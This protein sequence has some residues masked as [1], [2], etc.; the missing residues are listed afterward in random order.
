VAAPNIVSYQVRV[1]PNEHEV[2]V[3]LQLEG[4]AAEEEVRLEVPTWVPGDYAFMQ[5]GRDLF[6]LK[7][8]D[9]RTG[10]ELTVTR[11]HWQGFR[12]RGGQGSVLVSY[13][14][15]AYV[16]D[17]GEPCGLVENDYA[18]LLGTRYLR[19]PASPGPCRVTYQLPA[20]WAFH[21][22]SGASQVGEGPAW[23]YPSFEVL[24]DTPVVL[25]R[26]DC[27]ERLIQ[28]TPFYF[29]FLDNALGYESQVELLLDG[30]ARIV[31]ALYEVFGSFP[32]HDYTF[33][34]SLSPVNEWGLEHLSSSMC[35]L[36]PDLFIDP[37][38]R[39]YGM[40]VCA[41]ELFHAW[42]VRRLRPAPLKQFD[43]RNGSFTEG[44][45]VAEGFT[46]YY[47]F[48]ICTR[49][50]VYTPEQFFSAI[51]NYY[52]HLE[53]LPAYE[54]VS[55]VDSSVATYLNHGK[56]PGRCNNSIDY[57][58]K[59]MLIAF[60][61]DAALRLHPRGDSLDDAFRVFYEKFVDSQLGYTTA[62]VLQFFEERQPGLGQLLAREAQQPSGLTVE[63]HLQQLGFRVDR[64]SVFSLGLLFNNAT[65]PAIY[66]VLDSSPAGRC[67]LAPGDVLTR[68]NGF[69]FS[70]AGLMW[71]GGRA[72][73]V[74]LE[75]VRGQRALTMTVT[76]SRRNRISSLRWAGSDEQARRIQAWLRCDDFRPAAG[77]SFNLD[78]Y[79][80][81]HGI[82]TVL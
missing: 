13:R 56:Y 69:P 40:R 30:M 15:Y 53:D 38:K 54:R 16:P 46:R 78:F 20:G 35:G 7:A 11:E 1:L 22:A 9:A 10:K 65:G 63:A 23:D 48:L 41:H 81:F 79:E 57:Y 59:G 82:E 44:L 18:V 67:G 32:F 28:G 61:L 51:V 37:G 36:G 60:D 55:A 12:V 24:L 49:A 43:L 45:W 68:I 71:A 19:V 2:Q 52:R 77:Q 47:E 73:P 17:F 14:A 8:I 29:V 39:A 34:L 6:D 80:N 62:E 26:F 4:P 42:N 70:M 33:I 58:D 74:S 3:E 72:E 64:E 76:P 25:G 27:R 75:V 5:Y 21:H 66:N 31:E 50:G